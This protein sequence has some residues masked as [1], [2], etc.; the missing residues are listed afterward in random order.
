M[1][2]ASIRT[3]DASRASDELSPWEGS[4]PPPR[5]RRRFRSRSSMRS[6]PAISATQNVS[7]AKLSRAA[8]SRRCCAH[9]RALRRWRRAGCD[10][11]DRRR[12]G[13]YLRRRE[14][15]HV[16]LRRRRVTERLVMARIIVVAD[17]AT[18]PVGRTLYEER[19]ALPVLESAHASAQLLERISWAVADADEGEIDSRT[20]QSRRR[21]GPPY[22]GELHPPLVPSTA[23]RERARLRGFRSAGGS[24]R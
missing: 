17:S 24:E 23:G 6:P 1:V 12:A 8:E 5:R 22:D 14:S 10:A 2:P 3:S 13:P 18:E 20:P 11:L 21:S 4:P 7:S 9:R 15:L 19:V 16:H